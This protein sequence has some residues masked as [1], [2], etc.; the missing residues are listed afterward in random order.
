MENI[1]NF[2]N[3]YNFN[4]ILNIKYK[5]QK[6]FLVSGLKNNSNKIDKN[7]IFPLGSISKAYYGTMIIM[8]LDKGLINSLDDKIISYLPLFEHMT[9]FNKITILDCLLHTTGI[10]EI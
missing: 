4:G 5:K 10:S 7:T 2:L 1:N 8:L 9:Y 3:E 6:L